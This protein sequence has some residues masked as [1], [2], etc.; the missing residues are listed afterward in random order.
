MTNGI[1]PQ[2]TEW[3]FST[4]LGF[5]HHRESG[6]KLRYLSLLI[7]LVYEHWDNQKVGKWV[8]PESD[9]DTEDAVGLRM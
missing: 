1:R 9:E 7:V 3:V 5:Q 6:D 8:D 4:F 2:I